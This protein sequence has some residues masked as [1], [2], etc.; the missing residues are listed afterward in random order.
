[1][2][3]NI[4]KFEEI[5]SAFKLIGFKD[6][7]IVCVYKILASI[8]HLGDIEFSEVVSDDNTDNKSKIIDFAPLHRGKMFTG[9]SCMYIGFLNNSIINGYFFS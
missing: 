3:Y 5:N 4:I 1:M 9:F 2:Q 7:E 8:L 6:D